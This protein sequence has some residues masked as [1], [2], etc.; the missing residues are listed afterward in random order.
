MA[1]YT[2]GDLHLSLGTSKPMDIFH[3]WD[4]YVARIEQQWNYLVKQEDVVVLPGDISWAMQIEDCEADFAFIHAL[5]GHKVIIKGN[6][7]YWWATLRKM[8]N[9]CVEKGFSSITFIQNSCFIAGEMAIC[10]TRSWFFDSEE[11]HD[12]KIQNR[13][14]GR[15]EASLKAAGDKEKLVFLHYPPIYQSQ[16]A[17]NIIEILKKYGVKQCFY[18]HLHGKSHNFAFSGEDDGINYKLVSAD[19]LR[20]CPYLVK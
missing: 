8:E 15:L 17:E 3:G 11:A 20:F 10:G 19:A 4:N 16:R 5:P 2:I 9:F 14:V 13:E 18:G 12:E 6:H 7:D 1:I